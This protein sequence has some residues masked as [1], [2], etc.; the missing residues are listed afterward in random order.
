[1]TNSYNKQERLAICKACE[2]YKEGAGGSTLL[3]QCRKCGCLLTF[4]TALAS[5]KCPIDKW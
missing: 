3:T 2:Y 1:M 4:K 5:S